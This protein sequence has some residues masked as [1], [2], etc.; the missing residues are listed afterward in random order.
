MQI[1]TSLLWVL[2]PAVD[3]LE[4]IAVKNVVM[5]EVDHFAGGLCQ[6]IHSLYCFGRVVY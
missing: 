3:K 5:G 4:W 6:A 2:C 1:L